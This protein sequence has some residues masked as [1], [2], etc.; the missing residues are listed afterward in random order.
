[1]LDACA[2]S[3]THMHGICWRLLQ[4]AG[5]GGSGRQGPDSRAHHSLAIANRHHHPTHCY[6][7]TP[8]LWDAKMKFKDNN[9]EIT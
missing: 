3:N 6:Q 2:V 9:V 8:V 1:M 4:P 7:N 5:G